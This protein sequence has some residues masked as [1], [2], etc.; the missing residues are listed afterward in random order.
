MSI[1]DQ[2]AAFY[3]AESRQVLATLVRLLGDLDRAEE[4]L[5]DAFV[6]AFERWPRDGIPRNPRGWLVSTGRF[7]AIDALRRRG[8]GEALARGLPNPETEG[9][10]DAEPSLEPF[11]SL[12][13]DPLRLVFLCCHPALPI[14]ARVALALRAVC[15]VRTEEIARCFLVSTE[16]MKKRISRAKTLLR[17]ERV[18]FEDAMQF[19]STSPRP[20]DSV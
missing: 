9:D 11:D 8:R 19:L 5:Q 16:A 18:P 3:Q 20:Q 10:S 2:I 7:K 17:A 6:A 13:D 4:A 15:G 12:Q 1:S 14:D